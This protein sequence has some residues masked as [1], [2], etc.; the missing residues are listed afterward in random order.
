MKEGNEMKNPI[1]KKSFWI[2]WAASCLIIFLF[3]PLI[4][5]PIGGYT[6]WETS[7]VGFWIFI[8]ILALIL[9]YLG[10]LIFLKS[11]KIKGH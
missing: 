1:Q 11:K 9:N 7:E 2:I 8:L 10:H 4:T 3:P 6:E 5:N